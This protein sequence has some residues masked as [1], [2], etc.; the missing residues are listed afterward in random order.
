MYVQVF[1]KISSMLDLSLG[2][3]HTPVIALTHDVVD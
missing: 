2:L 3:L 1:I